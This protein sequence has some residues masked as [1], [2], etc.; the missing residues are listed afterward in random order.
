MAFTIRDRTETTLSEIN[1]TPLVDVMLVLLIIFMITA[2]MMSSSI[3]VNLQQAKAQ[4]AP[5]AKEHVIVTITSGRDVYV[6]DKPSSL[7]GVGGTVKTEL[8]KL[9]RRGPVVSGI[10][11]RAD[12][13]VDYGTVLQVID[14]LRR[15]DITKNVGLIMNPP[16]NVA[17]RPTPAATKGAR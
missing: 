3:E 5:S 13:A 8:E 4:I 16:G 2:P 1:V 7:E 9:E 17:P 11:I 6:G 12:K 14:N 10:A 15:A